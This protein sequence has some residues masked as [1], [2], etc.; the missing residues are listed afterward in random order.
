MGTINEYKKDPADWGPSIQ[1]AIDD[2]RDPD[3]GRWPD[4]SGGVIHF[5]KGRYPVKTPI[6][7]RCPGIHLIGEGG[8]KSYACTLE[9]RGKNTEDAMF[10][11]IS[12]TPRP[13][14]SHGF[15]LENLSIFAK[16]KG[17]AFR[18]SPPDNYL[19]PFRFSNCAIK[20]FAKVFEFQ[21]IQGGKCGT[22]GGLNVL[23]SEVTYNGQIIDATNGLLN[24]WQF[25]R[26][27][28]SKNGLADE[29]WEPTYAFDLF[30]G[31]NGA[32]YGCVIEG[33][34]R[35]FRARRYQGIRLEGCR[36]EDN[37]VSEDPVCLIGECNGV[38]I[39]AFHRVVRR[40]NKESSPPT[41]RLVKCRDYN[42]DP[43]LGGVQIWRSWEGR[44]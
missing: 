8:P 29:G 38:F 33:Q 30:G 27:L 15:N 32:M 6:I 4:T 5:P 2:L 7:V 12:K 25:N 23:D 3:G 19:R 11:M 16:K 35:A 1:Q 28:L 37:A 24:E 41:I 14:R 36:F 42:V 17:I 20:Y 39:Q 13:D 10:T 40:E 43:M 34:P 22:W 31:S 21:K 18:F 44:Y 9:W 26:C